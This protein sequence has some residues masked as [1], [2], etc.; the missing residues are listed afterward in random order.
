MRGAR[1]RKVLFKFAVYFRKVLDFLLGAPAGRAQRLQMYFISS[2][3]G[4]Y[5]PRTRRQIFLLNRS[6]LELRRPRRKF[7]LTSMQTCRSMALI[8]GYRTLPLFPNLLPTST[9]LQ[10]PLK[11]QSHPIRS[12]FRSTRRIHKR[13]Y[14]TVNLAP[15][16]YRSPL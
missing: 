2:S 12:R 8:G 1:C 9:F 6:S 11:K 10:A 4:L 5:S 3:Q 16:Y 13:R 15:H 14:D 7:C